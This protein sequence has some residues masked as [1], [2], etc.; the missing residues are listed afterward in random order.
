MFF[1]YTKFLQVKNQRAIDAEKQNLINQA[2]TLNGQNQQLSQSISY[3]N[4]TDFKEKV[5]RQ[6]LDLKRSGEI[7]YNFTQGSQQ[8]VVQ[9][10]PA[11]TTSNFQKWWNYF[12]GND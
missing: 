10:A 2:N 5:A 3:L 12:N 8:T 11:P 4:S 9:P 7:A 1:G 6:Q